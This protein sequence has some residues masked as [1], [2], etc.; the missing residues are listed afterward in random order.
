MSEIPTQLCS[1]DKNA[2]RKIPTEPGKL[3]STCTRSRKGHSR[4]EKALTPRE[5]LG[6]EAKSQNTWRRA[7]D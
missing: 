4:I 1:V 6:Q 5:E 2:S 3:L 7:L